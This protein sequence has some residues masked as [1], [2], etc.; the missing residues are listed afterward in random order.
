MNGRTVSQMMIDGKRKSTCL[1]YQG[2]PDSPCPQ[3]LD[4]SPEKRFPAIASVEGGLAE[5][6]L[7]RM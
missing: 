2:E 5:T 6:A 3:K 7:S 1:R 4:L